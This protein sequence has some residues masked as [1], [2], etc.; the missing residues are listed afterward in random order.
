[1][2]FF[3][4]PF[5]NEVDESVDIMRPDDQINMGSPFEKAVLPFLCHAARN[6]DDKVRILIFQ[7]LQFTD[8]SQRLILCR[9]TDTARI[10]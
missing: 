9:F 2:F 10:Q 3:L 5:F 6:G 1:M 7:M 4:L 8:F